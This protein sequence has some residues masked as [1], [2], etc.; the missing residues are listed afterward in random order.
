MNQYASYRP[1]PA[2]KKRL[3]G[4]LRGAGALLVIVSLVMV[5]LHLFGDNRLSLITSDR[6]KVSATTISPLVLSAIQESQMATA[7]NSAINADRQMDI[8]VAIQDLNNGKLYAYGL[9]NPFIAASVGKL[10]TANLYLHDVEMGKYSLSKH[11]SYG[12]A[13]YELQQ[14]I[15]QSD[16]QAWE[17]FNTLLTHTNLK[18]YAASI[19]IS[20][21]DPHQNT[22]TSG[23]IA[24]LLGKF[25]KG[26]LLNQGDTALLLSYM[27]QAN[28]TAYI[29]AS[30]PPG[31]KVYHKA[32]WLD[33]RVNDAAVIDNG[34][35]PYVLVIFSKQMSGNYDSANGQQL[36]AAITKATLAA[37]A[38]Q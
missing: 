14:M 11:L 13:K 22:L 38:Q 26:Q 27:H 32:G 8:G 15:E 20:N 23:D 5:G 18:T 12:T 24:L 36:F 25:Y 2:P 16:N 31:V 21:Y 19:G 34:R 28:E 10:I 7:I 4:P 17:D 37:F 9:T 1:A 35:H 30:V 33:D 3:P 6:Q 29:V